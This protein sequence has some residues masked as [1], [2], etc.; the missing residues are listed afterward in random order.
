MTFF[1][2][3]IAFFI[4]LL[5]N[6]LIVRHARQLRLIDNPNHR[7]SHVIPTPSGGGIGLMLAGTLTGLFLV[8]PFTWR[9]GCTVLALSFFLACLSLWD[10]LKPLP[11]LLRLGTQALMG[12]ILLFVL[13]GIPETQRFMDAYVSRTLIYAFLLLVILWWM[14]LFNFMDGIDGLAGTQAV[15]MLLAGVV[16]LA[17]SRS[18]IR[19]TPEW[20][21]MLCIVGATLG[22]L[23]SNWSPARIFMGDVG[24]IY[25]SFMILSL[26]LLS[27]RNEWIAVSPGLAMWAVLGALFVTDSTVTLLTRIV[28]GERWYE[29]HRSHVYQRLSRRLGGHR[30]VTLLFLA[31]NIVWLLPLA[32]ACVFIP[33]WSWGWMCLAYLPLV[34]TAIWLGAGQAERDDLTGR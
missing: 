15:F 14:N 28:R 9:A 17:L 29:A 21:W 7:S 13:G 32:A 30:I 23:V 12:A 25:L 24:S 27:I 4:T 1:L 33:R 16:L 22:F 20:L 3:L 8:W 6:V 31:V 11:V 19:A 5:C 2:P 18:E 10:D 26:A 34:A